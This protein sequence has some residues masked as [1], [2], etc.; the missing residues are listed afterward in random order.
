[1]T[2]DQ[3]DLFAEVDAEDRARERE[4]YAQYGWT[5]ETHGAPLQPLF[6]DVDPYGPA[7]WQKVA[8]EW[9]REHGN[10]ACLLR[11]HVWRIPSLEPGNS[12]GLGAQTR[13]AGE[14]LGGRCWP[15]QM[16]LTAECDDFTHDRGNRGYRDR[17]YPGQPYRMNRAKERDAAAGLEHRWNADGCY[18]VTV[19]VSRG[20]CLGCGWSGPIRDNERGGSHLAV[21]DAHDHAFPGWRELPVVPKRPEW[22][23]G[24][25]ARKAMARWVE[26]MHE[27]YPADWLERGGPI[28][29]DRGPIGSLGTRHVPNATGFGG[30]DLSATPIWEQLSPL[31]Q[32][33]QAIYRQLMDEQWAVDRARRQA[34][35]EA[36]LA[37]RNAAAKAA[38]EAAPVQ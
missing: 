8:G 37:A 22:G 28:R 2:T 31:Q 12:M 16:R 21:E 27:V 25:A 3:L 9:V 20:I 19:D 35:A 4:W 1:V 7:A 23:E 6:A 33:E 26:H 30:Y 34:K 14:F 11:C 13:P 38:Q 10:F 29:T 17:L 36:D 5:T 18:C 32:A 15:S 24:Q